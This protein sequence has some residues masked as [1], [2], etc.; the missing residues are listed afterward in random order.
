MG[1]T[2]SHMA[3][4]IVQNKL[5]EEIKA[6]K[7]DYKHMKSMPVGKKKRYLRAY[8]PVHAQLELVR[9]SMRASGSLS[10]ENQYD[11]WRG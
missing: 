9:A 6:I 3:R 5:S 7:W 10:Y 1:V 4:K 8:Q 2:Y 11:N